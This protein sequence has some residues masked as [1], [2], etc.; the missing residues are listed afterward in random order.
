MTYTQLAA[1]YLRLNDLHSVSR[2]L[3]EAE[4]FAL[5]QPQTIWAWYKNVNLI[6]FCLFDFIFINSL[7]ILIKASRAAAK[8]RT[9]L[10]NSDSRFGREGRRLVRSHFV[11]LCLC[12]RFDIHHAFPKCFGKMR[13]EKWMKITRRSRSHHL[14]VFHLWTTP[15]ALCKND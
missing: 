5:N 14:F 10:S 7:L 3:F 4:W 9:R 8:S 12:C 6:I 2:K 15:M 11:C 13:I 1:N